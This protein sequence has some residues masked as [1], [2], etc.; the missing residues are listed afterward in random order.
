MASEKPSPTSAMS[1]SSLLSNRGLRLTRLVWLSAEMRVPTRVRLSAVMIVT[2]PGGAQ[3]THQ[4]LAQGSSALE[5][6]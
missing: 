4:H 1:V 6:T 3:Q 5:S 2:F